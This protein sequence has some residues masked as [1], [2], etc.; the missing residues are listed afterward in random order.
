MMI[1]LHNYTSNKSLKKK[2]N[3]K[4]ESCMRKHWRVECK[5]FEMNVMCVCVTR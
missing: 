5:R 3:K 2:E 4:R 1:Q